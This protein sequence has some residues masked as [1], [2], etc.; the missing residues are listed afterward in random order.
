MQN[1]VQ[2]RAEIE[3]IIRGVEAIKINGM[4]GSALKEEVAVMEIAVYWSPHG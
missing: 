2:R 3:Q 1:M 4:H